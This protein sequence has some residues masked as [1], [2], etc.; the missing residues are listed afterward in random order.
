MGNNLQLKPNEVN[1]LLDRASA[2]T[3]SNDGIIA[4]VDRGGRPLGVRIESEALARFRN[5]PI[6]LS[7]AVDGALAEA[8]TGAFFANNTA[9]LTSRTVA[10]A[11]R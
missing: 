5:D 8:R 4:I 9:P 11:R 1:T 7:F 2:A 10:I 6:A 3:P